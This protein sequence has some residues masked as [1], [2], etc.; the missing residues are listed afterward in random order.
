VGRV[1]DGTIMTA[2]GNAIMWGRMGGG[3]RGAWPLLTGER[4]HYDFAAGHDVTPLVR[5][6]ER[7]ATC[8]GRTRTYMRNVNSRKPKFAF[9]PF[10]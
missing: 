10:G 4:A 6:M 5:V 3:G 7:F 2:T 9:L 1:G 8:A